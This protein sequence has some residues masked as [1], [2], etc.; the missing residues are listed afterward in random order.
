M[1]NFLKFSAFAIVGGLVLGSCSKEQLNDATSDNDLEFRS[2]SSGSS[3]KSVSAYWAEGATTMLNQTAHSAQT[4]TITVWNDF[5]NGTSGRIGFQRWDQTG[6][7]S[8]GRT[9]GA[10]DNGDATHAFAFSPSSWTANV[11]F[12]YGTY[13]SNEAVW[14][15]LRTGGVPLVYMGILRT[16]N[17]KKDEDAAAGIIEVGD[18]RAL[19]ED[20]RTGGAGNNRVII[21]KWNGSSWVQTGRTNGAGDN[22]DLL[23]F[24]VLK[25]RTG[26]TV[27][28]GKVTAETWTD[29]PVVKT[30][31]GSKNRLS[32]DKQGVGNNIG[33]FKMCDL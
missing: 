30:K 14:T 25:V 12:A 2:G 29:I 32:T 3:S 16:D 18:F 5:S 1:K 13:S 20:V 24:T 22:G 7:A 31:V 9:N 15:P 17:S 11:P 10:G 4:N 19:D 26:Y 28:G 33:L 6:N 8:F 21:Q 23:A 27:S